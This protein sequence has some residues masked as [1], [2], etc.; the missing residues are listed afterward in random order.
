MI[1]PAYDHYPRHD[2]RERIRIAAVPKF[3]LVLLAVTTPFALVRIMYVFR[4]Q[5]MRDFA[6]R[7][8]FQYI[9]PPAPKWWWHPS[10]PKISP[11]LPVRFPHDCHPSGKR[12]THVW[13]V[14]EGH[15]NGISVLIFDSIVGEGKGSGWCT[16]IASQTEQ[17]PFGIVRSPD[18]VIHSGG[19][20]VLHGV[21][22]LHF[23]WFMSIRR[24][25]K[26]VNR[27]RVDSLFQPS[28]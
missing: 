11:P 17:K 10:H 24:L 19:W 8:G 9:G 20:T 22:F 5:A 1:T 21:W 26:Y 7:W 28:C 25:D 12:I 14:I 16:I 18:R 2:W 23:S 6:A 15:H 4:A 27:L 13:N 3:L